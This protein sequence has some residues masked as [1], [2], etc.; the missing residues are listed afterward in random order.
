[1]YSTVHMENPTP[2]HPTTTHI[3]YYA[4]KLAYTWVN[5]HAGLMPQGVFTFKL[6]AALSPVK[7]M[8]G[9]YE[10]ICHNMVW[11]TQ[12]DPEMT[13]QPAHFDRETNVLI[14][15]DRCSIQKRLWMIYR[16]VLLHLVYLILKSMCCA[17]N[18]LVSPSEGGFHSEVTPDESAHVAVFLLK[19]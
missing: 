4:R 12:S 18:F 7:C 15:T 14:Y 11:S 2:P 6:R 3:Y 16:C 5:A 19:W 9:K 10:N 1:M 13:S 8:L 17:I